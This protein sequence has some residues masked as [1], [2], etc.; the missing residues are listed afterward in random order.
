[1][2]QAAGDMVRV[3][4][5]SFIGWEIQILLESDIPVIAFL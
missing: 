5:L 3:D 4:F 2:P 1:M